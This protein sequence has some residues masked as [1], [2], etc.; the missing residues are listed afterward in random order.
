[1]NREQRRRIAK[2]I[3]NKQLAAGGSLKPGDKVMLDVHTICMNPNWSRLTNKYKEWVFAH[4]A[5]VFTVEYDEAHM[6][7]PVLVCL[8]ED[9][10]KPKWLFY[11][12]DLKKM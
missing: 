9:N 10:T 4:G 11:V 2:N 7:D 5:D 6:V 1:M 8:A 3:A 12:G